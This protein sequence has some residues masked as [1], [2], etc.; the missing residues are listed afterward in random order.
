[1][2]P[3]FGP[4][5]TSTISHAGN[6]P[7]AAQAVTQIV[8]RLAT[9]IIAAVVSFRN[10]PG[11]AWRSITLRSIVPIKS[12]RTSRDDGGARCAKAKTGGPGRIHT[13]RY[14]KC[15]ACSGAGSH[16]GA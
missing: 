13:S 14:E 12:L 7:D 1:M 16:G 11:A 5:L 8:S 15:R 2:R 9:V 3:Q 10:A 6:G 4:H